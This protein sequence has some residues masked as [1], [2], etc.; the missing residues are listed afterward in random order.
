M[1]FL[2]GANGRKKRLHQWIVLEDH[3]LVVSGVPVWGKLIKARGLTG[4]KYALPLMQTLLELIP[5][6]ADTSVNVTDKNIQ[7]LL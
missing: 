1:R 3:S 7:V 2:P 4:W 6:M 5:V